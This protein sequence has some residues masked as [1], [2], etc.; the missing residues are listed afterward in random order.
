MSLRNG[1]LSSSKDLLET[2][3]KLGLQQT[4]PIELRRGMIDSLCA[5]LQPCSKVEPLNSRC[6]LDYECVKAIQEENALLREMLPLVVG[7]L[8]EC[9]IE[10]CVKRYN[11]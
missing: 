4:L 2:M 6:S 8:L 11:T 10:K 7:K 5:E 1:K 3:R 9:L